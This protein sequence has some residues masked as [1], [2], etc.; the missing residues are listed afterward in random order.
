[1]SDFAALTSLLSFLVSNRGVTLRDTARATGLK[2]KEICSRLD[3]L[4]LCG[5]PPYSPNDYISYRLV[6]SGEDAVIDL[7]FAKHF[8]RPLNFTPP[9][10]LAL[11]YALEHFHRGV[12]HESARQIED[13]TAV[14][15]Q[16]LHGRARETLQESARGFVVP[17]QTDRMR[18]LMGTLAESVDGRWITEIE[19]YSS[20]RGK[21]GS[22]RVHPYQILEIGT[23]FYL[24]AFCELA[25][26]TRHFRLERIRSARATDTRFQRVALKKRDA[27]RMTA[28]FNGH[29]TESLRIRLST[30]V[31]Q[32]IVDDWR[33]SPGARLEQLPDGRWDLELPLYNPFWAI[34]FL[35]G[36]GQEVELLAPAWLKKELAESLAS[37]LRA[38]E[39]A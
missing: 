19:Y 7:Q 35:T 33:D 15:Q 5:V 8:A 28:L 38:H 23:H 9:E 37:T 34:G 17:R 31:G 12:D 26:A 30:G 25:G 20:H 22:R 32:D 21:L 11:K 1:M 10:T 3:S 2:V 39:Q 6:G 4:T 29:A 14:L 27:G 13:L 36:L 18:A 16:A 24:Y